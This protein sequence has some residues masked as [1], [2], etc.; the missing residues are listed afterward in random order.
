MPALALLLG[1][2]V[3]FV[4]RL[5]FLVKDAWLILKWNFLFLARIA[6][7]FPGYLGKLGRWLM[8]FIAIAPALVAE[9]TLSTVAEFVGVA[10]SAA[11]CA[12]IA[13]AVKFPQI[14]QSIHGLAYFA[15][16]FRLDYGLACILCALVIRFTIR[17]LGHMPLKRLALPSLGWPKLPGAS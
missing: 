7:T 4:S 8:E 9:S 10:T 14:I 16:S 6:M 13:E 3:A 15:A 5:F 17:M 2:I 1:E 11:C 12:F